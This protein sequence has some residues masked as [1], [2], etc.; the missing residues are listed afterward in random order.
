MLIRQPPDSDVND[1]I[2][3]LIAGL[4]ALAVLQLSVGS[5]PYNG[6]SDSVY[7]LACFLAL[8]RCSTLHTLVL[9]ERDAV[10]MWEMPTSDDDADDNLGE[11]EAEDGLQLPR[12][13]RRLEDYR[14][15]ALDTA[16]AATKWKGVRCL[17][18]SVIATRVAYAEDVQRHFQAYASRGLPTFCARAALHVVCTGELNL[19]HRPLGKMGLISC[20]TA[21]FSHLE[22]E[23]RI[24][25]CVGRDA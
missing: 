18:L 12:A 22:R 1:G 16:L 13:I 5:P 24:A 4:P 6:K 14:W 10:Q 9:H 17:V 20:L 25:A 8:V 21:K 11:Y 23:Q 7:E 19:G 3:S 2:S 15:G